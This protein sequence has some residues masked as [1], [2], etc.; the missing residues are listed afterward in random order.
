MDPRDCA[1]EGAVLTRIPATGTQ[2]VVC[3][4]CG[5]IR[6]KNTQAGQPNGGNMREVLKHLE[7]AHAA[8]N[9]EYAATRS[10]DAFI[11]RDALSNLIDSVRYMIDRAAAKAL[12]AR[13]GV[14]Q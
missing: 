1:H 9:A 5:D 11:T 7:A 2:L 12:R 14:D 8:A 13:Q 4:D 3:L 6:Y 10:G